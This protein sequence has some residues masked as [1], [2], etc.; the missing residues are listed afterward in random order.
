MGTLPQ[1]R[2]WA[3]VLLSAK[4][5]LA[6]FDEKR[7]ST[8][9][10]LIYFDARRCAY[11]ADG[12]VVD[13]SIEGLKRCR[14]TFVDLD[15]QLYRARAD[16]SLAL[17]FSQRA[18][19]DETIPL[20]L[21]GEEDLKQAEYYAK[22]LGDYGRTNMDCRAELYA[23]LC[24]SRIER[25]RNNFTEA[26]RVATEAIEAGTMHPH[27]RVGALIARAEAEIGQEKADAAV[28]DFLDAR[29]RCGSNLRSRAIC[30]LRVINTTLPFE[31]IA[32]VYAGS[33]RDQI[34]RK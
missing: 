25:K 34:D 10:D 17:A 20:T 19:L 22:E 24:R 21:R 30:L 8:Y 11:G 31:R 15:H 27:L 13:E 5:L 7:I 9:V 3:L 14:K 18:R 2:P 1:R 6:R 12:L 16:Y 28:T 23:S 26:V 32:S 33:E 29:D 4:N